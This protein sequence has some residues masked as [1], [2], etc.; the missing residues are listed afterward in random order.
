MAFSI[1]DASKGNSGFEVPMPTKPAIVP[2]PALTAIDGLTAPTLITSSALPVSDS[3]VVP[4]PTPA[5]LPDP[6]IKEGFVLPI[7]TT[8]RVLLPV[9]D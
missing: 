4:I 1:K 2:T 9:G 5:P 7:L 6:T 8:S 3:C